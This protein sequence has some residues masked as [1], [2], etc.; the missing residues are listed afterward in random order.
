M[1]EWI[2]ERWRLIRGLKRF[3]QRKNFS[4][5]ITACRPADPLQA[6]IIPTIEARIKKHFLSWCWICHSA[7]D[8]VKPRPS[9]V[10]L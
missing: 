7:A 1:G 9:V 3:A 4:I 5:Q 10:D 8:T 2:T 6:Q